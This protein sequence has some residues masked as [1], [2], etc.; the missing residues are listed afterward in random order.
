M[1]DEDCCENCIYFLE[2]KTT[3]FS[4]G[5]PRIR[6]RWKKP[7]FWSKVR[8][9]LFKT[10]MRRLEMPEFAVET[11]KMEENSVCRK[12]HTRTLKDKAE[13]CGDYKA[14]D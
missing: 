11:I 7:S 5:G 12:S 14:K 6:Y 3:I 4:R 9:F 2:G 1:H 10:P 8:Y 13:W